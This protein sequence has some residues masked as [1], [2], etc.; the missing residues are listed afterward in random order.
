MARHN[1]QSGLWFCKS[2]LRLSV[3]LVY[4]HKNKAVFV[5]K[6]GQIH[7]VCDGQ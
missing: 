1:Y 5:L 4:F 2:H 3:S 6:K 7:Y